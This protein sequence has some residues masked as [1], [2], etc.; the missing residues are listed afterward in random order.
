MSKISINHHKYSFVY[1]MRRNIFT[2]RQ[3]IMQF[4]D[5]IFLWKIKYMQQTLLNLKTEICLW[6]AMCFTKFIVKCFTTP[7]VHLKNSH[8]KIY[9]IP[10]QKD[11]LEVAL[12]LQK[13]AIEIE[14]SIL[15]VQIKKKFFSS[16]ILIDIEVLWIKLI[17]N[18]SH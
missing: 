18:A 15:S 1:G 12:F 4:L 3:T 11:V 6:H 9:G 8:I 5:S 2:M 17:L 16:I 7:T 10:M 14:K 13:N